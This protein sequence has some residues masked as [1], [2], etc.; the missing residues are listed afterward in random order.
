MAGLAMAEDIPS[1]PEVGKAAPGLE[2]SDLAGAHKGK[3]VDYVKVR[4]GEPT[5]YVLLGDDGWNRPT[6]R[7]LRMLDDSITKQNAGAY[8]VVVR[9][10]ED[11]ERAAMVLP[12]AHAALRLTSTAFTLYPGAATGPD[13][14]S[15]NDRAFVTT[16]VCVKGKVAATFA[17]QS[18]DE[19]RAPAIFNAL[20]KAMK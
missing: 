3:K 17:D 10:T 7:Y 5:I 19:A 11:K 9:L 16:V 12:R 8:L 14:W 13:D 1:G 4:K 15:I 18:L 6:A 2:V 20:K